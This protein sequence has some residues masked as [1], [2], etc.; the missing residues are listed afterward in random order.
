M[1]HVGIIGGG[2][3]GLCSAWYLQR[4]GHRVTVIDQGDIRD[5]CSFGN[6]GMIVPSHFVPLAAPGMISKG[7]RWMFRSSSPFYVRP[8]I[9]A[10]LLRW[11]W[12]FYRNA[13]NSKIQEAAPHLLGLSLFSKQCYQQ[14]APELQFV[15]NERGLMMLYQTKAT[16]D[17]ELEIVEMAHKLGVEAKVLTASEVQTM[18]PHVK[19][20][21]LGG[22]YFPDDAHL[23][24][25]VVMKALM[26]NVVAHGGI[27][28]TNE[29]VIGFDIA[30]RS[31]RS[32]NTDRD[33]HA[34]DEV[35][36]AAGSWSMDLSRK[37]GLNI[38]VQ[39]GKGYSF[40]LNNVESNITTPTIFLEDRVAVTPMVTSLRFGGTM[41]IGGIN[42]NIDMNRVRGIV[43]AIPKYYPEM[44]VAMPLKKDVWCGLRPCSPDGLP[45][46]GRPRSLEN[47]IV[48]TGHGMMG[49]ALAP[50]TARIVADII[51]GANLQI[52]VAAFAPD[53]FHR[54]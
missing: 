26:E 22:I 40:T 33:N 38:P 9:S 5:G 7:I 18:E 36:L 17:E 12:L 43:D 39:A 21:A 52:E 46:I 45:Y 24:P 23:T 35:V 15:L 19:V 48:A 16:G 27:L 11:G 4:S 6:A 37:L 53:R 51:D 25:P 1:K 49:V 29:T 47:L 20:T 14:L 41:E 30:H 34:F 31:I 3:V 44:K 2:I 13:T 10:D 32:V 50:G 28:L 42:H 54:A 8:T